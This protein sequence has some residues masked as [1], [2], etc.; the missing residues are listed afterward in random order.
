MVNA[1]TQAFLTLQVQYTDVAQQLE[2]VALDGV[3][4]TTPLYQNEIDI[5]PA[6]RAGFV[7]P[8]LPLGQEG[9]FLTNGYNTGPVGNP[10]TPQQLM[11]IFGTDS[12]KVK[13]RSRSGLE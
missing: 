7:V 1:S 3:P 10:N 5:P 12:A 2:V 4:L 6:G 11:K 9:V 13:P 8:G